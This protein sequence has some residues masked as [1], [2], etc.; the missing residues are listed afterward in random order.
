MKSLEV[1]NLNVV[2]KMKKKQVEIVSDVSFK[3]EKGQC[4]CIVGESGSGKSM[5]LKAIMGLLDHNF[6]VQGEA[7]LGDT[8]LLASSKETLR[9]MR[10]KNMTMI[11]QNPMVCFD[12]LYRIEY[13]MLETFKAHTNWSKKEI[14]QKSISVLEKMQINNPQEVLKKYPHQLSGGM[15][16][17][18]MIGIA[19]ALNPDILIADEPTTAIDSI[20]QYEIMQEFIRLKEMGVTMVFITHDLGVASLISD[21]VVV[22]N[23]GKIVDSGTFEEIKTSAK[24][25]YTKALVA[26]KVAVMKAYKA[27]IGGVIID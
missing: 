10:G 1:N 14:Y 8:N 12:S 18:I 5:S 20:T 2:Y 25:E 21:Y 3:V 19:L 23:K 7:F 22:M 6:I 26:Q 24:D 13:Q 11:L 16:Q 17:R 27:K 15:L 9:K 4:L